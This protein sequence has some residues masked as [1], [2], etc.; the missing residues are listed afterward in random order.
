[1][2]VLAL[3]TTTRG[4]SMAVIEDDRIVVER[5]G[6]PVRSHAERL[7][8]D[9][10]DVLKSATLGLTDIDVF[11]VAIGP[12][13]FTG[14][15][16]GIAT[17]QGLAFVQQRRIAPVSALEALAQTQAATLPPGTLIGVW[18]DAHRRDVFS[19]LYRVR[20]GAPFSADR[21]DELDPPAVGDPIATLRRWQLHAPAVIVGDGAV[22]Q[23]NA[24]G[25]AIPVRP[26]QVLAGTIGVMAALA[27][28]QPGGTVDPGAVQPLYVRRP[29][30]ELARERERGAR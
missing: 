26:P 19:A 11:A 8:G 20:D 17:V 7:P 5:A 9:L 10:L 25:P 13:S 14:L 21:I 6:D 23:S 18:I 4:G 16:V 27:A 1:M 2:R 15:R 22:A 3:D 29:D 28:R 24:I 12:G 30:A